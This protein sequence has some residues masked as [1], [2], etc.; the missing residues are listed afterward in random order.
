MT[1][2]RNDAI[3]RDVADLLR[4]IAS[5]FKHARV[6]GPVADPPAGIQFELSCSNP[7]TARV[8]LYPSDDDI[9]MHLGEDTSIELP[10]RRR[11]RQ[12]RIA[13]LGRILEAIVNGRFDETVWRVRD[14]VVRSKAALYGP[15]GKPILRPREWHGLANLL[16]D[17]RARRTDIRYRPYS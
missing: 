6:E 12:E 9:D 8:V 7:G 14:S 10:K 1:T 5:E 3:L 15:D 16:P 4:E 17:P 13:E 2:D 11:D